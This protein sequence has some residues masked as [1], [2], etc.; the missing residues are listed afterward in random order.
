[1]KFSGKTDIDATLNAAFAAV[2]DFGAFEKLAIHAGAGVARTDDMAMPGCGMMWDIRLNYRGKARKI[3]AELV[4]Y[5]PP[6][7]LDFATSTSG[8]NAT[9]RVELLA[10]S[11]RQTRAVVIL[12]IRARSLAARL[13]LQSGRLVKARLNKRFK[14]RIHKFGQEVQARIQS[15]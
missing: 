7:V 9:I 6:E 10:L 3:V 4:D 12:D 15:A 5:D 13:A 1:M 11:Q 8:F 14:A 2:A